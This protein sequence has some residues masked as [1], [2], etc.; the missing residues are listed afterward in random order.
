VND[1]DPHVADAAEEA[2]MMQLLRMSGA[3]SAMPAFRE[4][5]VRA[6]VHS[7]WQLD[8]RRRVVR[9]RVLIASL[10]L[11]SAAALAVIVGHVSGRDQPRAAIGDIVATVE[12]IDG[13][14]APGPKHGG[15]QYRERSRAQGSRAHW[16]V[17]RDG[18]GRAWPV[19]LDVGSRVRPVAATHEAAASSSGSS[20]IA[21]SSLQSGYVHFPWTATPKLTLSP[22]LRVSHSAVLGHTTLTPWILGEWALQRR[23]TISASA[24][25]VHQAPQLHDVFGPAG[26]RDL[27]PESAAS[28]DAGVEHRVTGALD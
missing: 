28:F 27:R 23:W 24:G 18:C 7:R 1:R 10:T 13:F 15:R 26:S 22:S 5:R 25:L 21:S 3:R 19:R 16:R 11:A 9:T 6:A 20:F 14:A 17:G 2:A 12:Q 4:A 8:T